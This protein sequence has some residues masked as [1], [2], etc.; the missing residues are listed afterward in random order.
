MNNHSLKRRQSPDITEALMKDIA[1]T[2]WAADLEESTVAFEHP[3]QAPT[4][5]VKDHVTYVSRDDIRWNS[6]TSKFGNHPVIQEA[7]LRTEYVNDFI[8][9]TIVLLCCFPLVRGDPVDSMFGV[10][11]KQIC[12]RQASRQ[13]TSSR[14]AAAQ[15]ISKKCK[16]TL[17][18]SNLTCSV[19]MVHT[20]VRAS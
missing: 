5:H 7:F 1:F 4:R 20:E 6:R 3:L 13:P 8:R 16:K 18:W 12:I 17:T 9:G 15:L 10:Q 2:S 11:A 19:H 14:L